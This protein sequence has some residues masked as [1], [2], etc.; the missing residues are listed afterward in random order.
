MNQSR[1]LDN[2][3]IPIYNTDNPLEFKRSCQRIKRG[4]YQIKNRWLANADVNDAANILRKHLR[5]RPKI[6]SPF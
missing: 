4:L 2:N 5:G 1:F 3:P 6:R